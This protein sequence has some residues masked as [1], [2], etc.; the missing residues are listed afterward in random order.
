M[1][2]HIN[3]Y[4][5]YTFLQ[6]QQ[7]AVLFLWWKRGK[8]FQYQLFKNNLE[9]QYNS[10]ERYEYTWLWRDDSPLNAFLQSKRKHLLL[11]LPSPTFHIYQLK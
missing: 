2:I 5:K 1:N 8:K 10:F 11:M 6:E 3:Q 7:I 4:I 9:D